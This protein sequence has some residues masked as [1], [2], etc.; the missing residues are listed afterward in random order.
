MHATR[1]SLQRWTVLASKC[2]GKNGCGGTKCVRRHSRVPKFHAFRH[3]RFY[4]GC[5]HLRSAICPIASYF[6]DGCCSE[7]LRRHASHSS[8]PTRVPGDCAQSPDL[9]LI[10]A[11]RPYP[12][13]ESF[14]RHFEPEPFAAYQQR[15]R[16]PFASG[17]PTA[18]TTR[19]D[20]SACIR[21]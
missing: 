14:R 7:F 11:L 21:A 18:S 3:K 12:I 2:R 17:G 16:H 13:V 1:T 20:T 9:H 6:S 15:E 5:R 4:S 8:G 19:D 10:P